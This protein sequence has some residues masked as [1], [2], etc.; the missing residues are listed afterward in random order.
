MF[1]LRVQTV[2]AGESLQVQE[3]ETAEAGG[4]KVAYLSSSQMGAYRSMK[5]S[6]SASSQ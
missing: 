5:C 3:G 4:G 2:P 6:Q 1:R